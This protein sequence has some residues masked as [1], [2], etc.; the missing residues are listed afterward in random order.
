MYSFPS[1]C[2]CSSLVSLRNFST[3]RW[4]FSSKFVNKKLWWSV[5]VSV[6][7]LKFLRCSFSLQWPVIEIQL[8]NSY[9]EIYA[10]FASFLVVFSKKPLI[11]AWQLDRIAM[12]CLTCSFFTFFVTFPRICPTELDLGNTFSM[13]QTTEDM[14]W[15]TFL[16]ICPTAP[17]LGSI[18]LIANMS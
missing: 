14:S 1:Q 18:F 5:G 7:I 12:F 6:T 4:D 3:T 8:R 15:E 16:S 10:D 9:T 13:V 11:A 2:T 17:H